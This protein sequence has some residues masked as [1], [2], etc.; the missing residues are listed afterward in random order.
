[1]GEYLISV[2][3]ILLLQ[4]LVN[5]LQV[6]SQTYLRYTFVIIYLFSDKARIL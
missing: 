3:V 6:E 5:I 2:N 4:M 1:M